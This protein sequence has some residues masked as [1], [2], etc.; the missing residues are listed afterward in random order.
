[1][2]LFSPNDPIQPLRTLL[3]TLLLA[4]MSAVTFTLQAAGSC[5]GTTR[6]DALAVVRDTTSA[7]FAAV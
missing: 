2:A 7:L 4:S 6:D 3:V 5:E 1:M